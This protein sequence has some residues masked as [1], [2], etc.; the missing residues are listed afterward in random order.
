MPIYRLQQDLSPYPF[1][2]HLCTHTKIPHCCMSVHHKGTTK[3]SFV[4][5]ILDLILWRWE[6]IWGVGGE[7]D[8]LMHVFNAFTSSMSMTMYSMSMHLL[9]LFVSAIISRFKL[10]NL[11]PPAARLGSAHCHCS[12]E[13]HRIG[14]VI[15]SHNNFLVHTPMTLVYMVLVFRIVCIAPCHSC[16]QTRNAH[17]A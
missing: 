1:A 16:K 2:I 11:H 3:T 4:R 6:N 7:G 13:F 10:S 12:F 15:R 17:P 14:V 5:I 8:G 9:L